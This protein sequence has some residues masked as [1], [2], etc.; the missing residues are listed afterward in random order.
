MDNHHV[1]WVNQLFLWPCSIARL[2]FIM[3]VYI[4]NKW[5]FSIAF[6]MS[7]PEGAF[8]LPGLQKQPWKTASFPARPGNG[9]AM[10]L[11]ARLVPPHLAILR[12]AM[13]GPLK[14]KHRKTHWKKNTDYR[15][16]QY[17]QYFPVRSVRFPISSPLTNEDIL[18]RLVSSG[19]TTGNIIK[20]TISSGS[21]TWYPLVN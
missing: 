21:N 12:C 13:Q 16:L 14:E 10:L 5:P 6:C 8:P 3:F 1:Q 17:L 9:Q 2:Y 19:S 4:K 18:K 7:V 15:L 11:Q 20:S